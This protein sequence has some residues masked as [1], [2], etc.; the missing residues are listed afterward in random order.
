[1]EGRVEACLFL[2]REG[3]RATLPSGAALAALLQD[4]VAEAARPGLLAGR[5][6]A[7]KPAEQNVCACFGVGVATLRACILTRRLTTVA[8]VGAALSAGTNCGSCVPEIREILR[9]AH[10]EAA[11]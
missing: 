11:A 7:A 6:L 4:Q 10:A 1:V 8:E 9:D 3:S 2:Q 5:A